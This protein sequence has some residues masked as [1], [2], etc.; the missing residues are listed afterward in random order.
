MFV[1]YYQY[2]DGKTYLVCVRGGYPSKNSV[3]WRNCNTSVM[4]VPGTEDDEDYD[5]LDD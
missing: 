5:K 1:F 2:T 4:L 3:I